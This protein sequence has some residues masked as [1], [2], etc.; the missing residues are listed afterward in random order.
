MRAYKIGLLSILV[1]GVG[2]VQSCKQKKKNS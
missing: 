1:A 2:I